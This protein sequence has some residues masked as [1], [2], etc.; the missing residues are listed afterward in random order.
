MSWSFRR[1]LNWMWSQ[2][3]L[4]MIAWF[5]C[6]IWVVAAVKHAQHKAMLSVYGTGIF[7][8]LLILPFAAFPAL[9]GSPPLRPFRTSPL[10][11]NFG[12]V[13]LIGVLAALERNL[14][15]ASMYS[16]GGSLKT[17]L[18]GFNVFATFFFS[19]LLGVDRR[20]RNCLFRGC[21]GLRNSRAALQWTDTLL[22]PVLLC[23]CGGGLVTAICDDGAWN[24]GL[25]G[26]SLQ[27][28]S[29]VAYALRYVLIKKMLGSGETDE[30]GV[31]VDRNVHCD[32]VNGGHYAGA[33]IT[34]D[35][36]ERR[37]HPPLAE[38]Q[39]ASAAD[40]A[41]SLQQDGGLSRISSISTNSISSTT[42]TLSADNAV[43]P[44][45]R[46][47]KPSKPQ[48]A[49]VS[50]PVT[51]L[52]ALAFLFLFERHSSLDVHGAFIPALD[53]HTMTVPN[54]V[55]AS[56]SGSSI[57][58][59][60]AIERPTGAF[61]EHDLLVP[62]LEGP[63]EKASTREVGSFLPP[64][65]FSKGISFAA[66]PLATLLFFAVG[67]TGI[68]VAELQLVQLT[69]PLTVSVLSALHNVVIVLFFVLRDGEEFRGGQQAGFAVSTLGV[70]GYA[71]I[72]ERQGRERGQEAIDEEEG[73][74]GCIVVARGFPVD[75]G[76]ERKSSQGILV[77]NGN[78]NEDAVDQQEVCR[79]VVDDG[80]GGNKQ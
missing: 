39:L 27:L 18:H 2:W 40:I 33:D 80:G 62:F 5:I 55:P 61:H 66:P 16:I 26:V 75:R 28:A 19:S 74:G 64:N 77:S 54:V 32:N 48:I 23:V 60:S 12:R 20:G 45:S 36:L 67:V 68:L 35:V 10:G 71:F 63:N 47:R 14:T 72:K 65:V 42:S 21:C 24:G 41:K 25:V 56:T 58:A 44:S 11:R 49:L 50:Q 52:L 51:G 4:V 3:W 73:G 76:G 13:L 43:V 30:P 34:V 22:L 59:Q 1:C 29:G 46:H 15:N 37:S 31:R 57:P 7:A 79:G 70:I 9:S 38:Q 78:N 17:A 69:S 6:A 8:T 53:Q